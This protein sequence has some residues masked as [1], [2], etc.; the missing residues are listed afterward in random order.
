MFTVIKNILHSVK[1]MM[2]LTMLKW[3]STLIFC[4]ECANGC[5][6]LPKIQKPHQNS[7]CKNS[8]MKQVAHIGPRTVRDHCT[9]FSYLGNLMPI[10]HTL[11]DCATVFCTLV[12][13]NG[14]TFED[15]FSQRSLNQK[16]H[17]LIFTTN[18]RSCK[19]RGHLY[20]TYSRQC[21]QPVLYL[22]Q[23]CTVHYLHSC[24]HTM[25]KIKVVRQTMKTKKSVKTI[26]KI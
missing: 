1:I 14:H 10:L 7:R 15:C 5:T 4:T 3:A 6:N 9:R 2:T 20:N 21:A 8:D 24:C 13:Q 19:I 12:S 18:T 16:T 25:I 26:I 22:Q 23:T 11:L 17:I